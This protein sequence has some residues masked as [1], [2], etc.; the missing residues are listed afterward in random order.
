MIRMIEA[1]LI[2]K[3][4]SKWWPRV[5]ECSQDSSKSATALQI[6]SMA[7]IFI[8]YAAFSGLALIFFVSEMVFYFFIRRQRDTKIKSS[9]VTNLK[10]PLWWY[11][12]NH[13]GNI[14][15]LCRIFWACTDTFF[16]EIVT[17][18]KQPLW[19]FK[20]KKWQYRFNVNMFY[21]YIA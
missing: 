17:N 18:L 19:W 1:G 9:E 13:G 4:H 8:V 10:Q 3:F 2:A 20:F 5:S 14:H 16:S 6:D 21:Y 11:K 15:C 7:G 12:F